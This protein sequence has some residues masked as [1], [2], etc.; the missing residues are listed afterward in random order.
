MLWKYQVWEALILTTVRWVFVWLVMN[1]DLFRSFP[2]FASLSAAVIQYFIAYIGR[3]HYFSRCFR[4]IP[5][6]IISLLVRIQKELSLTLHP[7][8]KQTFNWWT[9]RDR[10][11]SAIITCVKTF[12]FLIRKSLLATKIKTAFLF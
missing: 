8:F 12:L 9:D 1:C 7:E 11:T 4:E 2:F 3:I 10:S 5:S 6:E